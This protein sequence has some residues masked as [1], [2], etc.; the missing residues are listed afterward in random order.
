MKAPRTH[1]AVLQSKQ[2]DHDNDVATVI[3]RD[4][5]LDISKIMSTSTAL[6]LLMPI[7]EGFVLLF[8]ACKMYLNF[9][10]WNICELL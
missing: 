7:Q 4:N 5:K 2:I 3:D 1:L 9:V 8:R 6:S 10:I